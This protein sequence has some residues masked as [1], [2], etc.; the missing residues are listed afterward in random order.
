M[1][2]QQR[3]NEVSMAL[4]DD[5][6]SFNTALWSLVRASTGTATVASKGGGWLSIATAATANDYTVIA[7]APIVEWNPG[8]PVFFEARIQCTEVS[9]ADLV[10]GLIDTTTSGI[11]DNTGTPPATF[12][13]A[14][15][16]RPAGSAI[17]IF[18][19]SSGSTALPDGTMAHTLNQG[20]PAFAS[21]TPIV[22]GMSWDPGS[23]VN[24]G[25]G[26]PGRVVPWANGLAIRNTPG[27]DNVSIP[28]PVGGVAPMML[29]AG[30]RAGSGSAEALLVDYLGYDLVR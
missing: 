23:G 11:L 8:K 2:S 4:L 25:Q 9:A 19:A 26:S 15:F 10:V 18:R 29:V 1:L 13:G 6:T 30:V 12:H 22:L 24:P 14:V 27:S 3:N 20:T 16:Y 5:M 7:T 21:G 28:I 17:W